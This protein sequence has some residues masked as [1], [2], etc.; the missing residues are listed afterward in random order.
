MLAG[1][2]APSGA[3]LDRQPHRRRPQAQATAYPPFASANHILHIMTHESFMTTGNRGILVVRPG[4]HAM[5]VAVEVNVA[6]WGMILC[7]LQAAQQLG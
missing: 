2:T 3:L 5:W 7:A 1:R 4:G 6:L